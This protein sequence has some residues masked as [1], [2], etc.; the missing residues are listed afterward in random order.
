MKVHFKTLALVALATGLLAGSYAIRSTPA[1]VT[2]APTAL[3]AARQAP[4]Q[5]VKQVPAG[6][7]KALQAPVPLLVGK[8]DRYFDASTTPDAAAPGQAAIATT[9]NVE[10]PSA[11]PD[12]SVAR[13]SIET[14]GYR[15][16]RDL[17]RASDGVWHARAMRGK[18]EVAVKV[19][20]GG[21][22]SAD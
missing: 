6:T 5:P 9:D 22:V 15:N 12:N 13:A 20:A 10:Q 19:D 17:M 14:D 8:H 2:S 1:A 16:V 3:L 4:P 21:S 11:A 7:M 18:T